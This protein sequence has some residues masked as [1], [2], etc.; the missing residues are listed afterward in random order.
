VFLEKKKMVKRNKRMNR[1]RNGRR[2]RPGG[3]VVPPGRDER[4][5]QPLSGSTFNPVTVVRNLPLFGLRTRRKLPYYEAIVLVGPANSSA[6]AQYIWSA[7]GCFDPNITGAGHQ[8]MGFDQMMLF[9]NHYTVV[10]SRIKTLIQNASGTNIAVYSSLM[11]SGSTSVSTDYINNIENGELVYTILSVPGASGANAS[12][13]TSV[14]CAKFQGLSNIMDDPDM[15]GD[16]SSNPTEQLYY[17][18]SV[19]NPASAAVASV[20]VN[21]E[22]EFDVIF[23]EPKKGP[24]S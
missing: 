24:L 22:L 14:N 23:H 19:W 5:A 12:L 16:A 6:T 8:P 17:I 4:K 20:L 10:G 15:R 2:A 13:R 3:S 7:N 11:V 1:R 21:V 18:V 9:Y